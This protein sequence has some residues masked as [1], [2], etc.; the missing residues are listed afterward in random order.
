MNRNINFGGT[1][2][3]NQHPEMD[4]ACSLGYF[5]ALG[6]RRIIEPSKEKKNRMSIRFTFDPIINMLFTRAEGV[7]SV[8]AL[9]QHLAPKAADKLVDIRELFDVP[10]RCSRDRRG[11]A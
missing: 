3:M 10:T 11:R 5:W 8:R 1:L 2:P 7:L 9:T 6:G 4:L